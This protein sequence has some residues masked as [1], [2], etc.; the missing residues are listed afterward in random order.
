MARKRT[1]VLVG[2]CSPDAHML[3]SAISSAVPHATVIHVNDE[4]RLDEL[5][6]PDALLLINRMLEGRF[7]LDSGVGLIQSLVRRGNA[8]AVMLIS[9]YADAQDHAVA[10][11]AMRGFGKAQLYNDATA[12]LLRQAICCKDD[13]AA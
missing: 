11:G 13:V 4:Q 7:S 9:N 1:V 12:E 2:H 8:A 10:A 3:R 6:L 5:H